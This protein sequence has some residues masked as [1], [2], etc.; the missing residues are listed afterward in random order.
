MNSY[1]NVLFLFLIYV[2]TIIIVIFDP[3]IYF[4]ATAVACLLIYHLFTSRNVNR[5]LIV[6]KDKSVSKL[7]F[8]LKETIKES[9]EAYKHFLSLSKTLGSGVVMID[10]D[11]VIN[12]ANKDV[13]NFFN[14]NMNNLKYDEIRNIK[15]LYNFIN[16]AY[17]MEKAKRDQIFYNE[18]YYDI[19]STP[20]V[21]NSLFKGCLIVIHDITTLRTAEN[22]QKRF[23]ADVSHELKTPLS[24][25]KG[26]SELLERDKDMSLDDRQEFIGIIRK[27]ASRMET[28]LSDLLIISKMDR[29]D[30]D[31]KLSVSDIKTVIVESVNILERLAISKNIAISIDVE[32]KSLEF[33]KVKL[34]HALINL[35]KNAINYTDEGKISVM[36]KIVDNSYLITIEDTGIGI[37]NNEMDNI[38]KR[39]YRIDGARS[40]DTGGSGL[41]LS[42]V[43]NV[44]KKHGGEIDV[45]S[46][47]NKGTKFVISLPM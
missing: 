30:Y 22:F 28:I 35:I 21:E 15:P 44:V 25:I 10:E 31:L 5:K 37:P 47:I 4:S 24:S 40:R 18:C 11:G 39:F 27:E 14:Q 7:K 8:R 16:K 20:I 42:I 34:E 38:F 6:E 17:L 23:T 2:V 46:E 9:E 3:D 13:F 32:S 19:K 29:I 33:D 1:K 12:F 26:V 45:I 36:G 41:G 43:K